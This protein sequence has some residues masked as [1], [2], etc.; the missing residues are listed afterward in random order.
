MSQKRLFQAFAT[1]FFSMEHR[2]ITDLHCRRVL[3]ILNSQEG[4][5]TISRRDL[6]LQL[7]C[8]NGQLT[9]V[10]ESLA[11]EY[12]LV[13]CQHLERDVL[14]LA[15][16]WDQVERIIGAR[17]PRRKRERPAWEAQAKELWKEYAAKVEQFKKDQI[18]AAQAQ[19]SAEPESKPAA[20]K[21]P[22]KSKA[23]RAE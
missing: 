20:R 3:E 17:V 18:D 14:A 1:L 16:N 6:C 21:T 4:K 12:E 22:R 2:C 7:W 19:P 8:D 23:K 15:V 10:L 9:D 5:R 11:T 13:T